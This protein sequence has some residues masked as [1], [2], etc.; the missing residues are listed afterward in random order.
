MCLCF[1]VLKLFLSNIFFTVN[2]HPIQSSEPYTLCV[3]EFWSSVLR[4]PFFYHYRIPLFRKLNEV[5]IHQYGSVCLEVSVQVAWKMLGNT[6]EV[7][8]VG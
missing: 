6:Q 7:L 8:V 4:T 3:K 1:F 5:R 2:T